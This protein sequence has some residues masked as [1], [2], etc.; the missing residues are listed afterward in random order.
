[1]TNEELQK[2]QPG[3]VLTHKPSNMQYMVQEH[4]G[5]RIL[6]LLS[7]VSPTIP[8]DRI[9]DGHDW[10]I[11]IIMAAKEPEKKVRPYDIWVASYGPF[12]AKRLALDVPGKSFEDACDKWFGDNPKYLSEFV[13]YYGVKLYPNEEDAKNGM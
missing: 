9:S 4:E 1:M 11:S 3:T 13:T 12:P 5:K 8:V 2:L 10:E 6:F 7:V